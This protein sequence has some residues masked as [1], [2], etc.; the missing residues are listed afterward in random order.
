MR[1]VACSTS[2]PTDD[3]LTCNPVLVNCDHETDGDGGTDRVNMWMVVSSIVVAVIVVLV[4]VIAIGLMAIVYSRW[5]TP[6]KQPKMD[7]DNYTDNNIY[8]VPKSDSPVSDVDVLSDS[9]SYNLENPLYMDANS[10]QPSS[11]APEHTPANTLHTDDPPPPHTPVTEPN[12][13]LE[14]AGDGSVTEPHYDTPHSANTDVGT[15]SSDRHTC[16]H[17]QYEYIH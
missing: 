15:D 12:S 1:L 11:D 14:R 6:G 3:T 13:V 5:R 16:K 4:L 17:H 10:S 9:L 7:A 2:S 8:T